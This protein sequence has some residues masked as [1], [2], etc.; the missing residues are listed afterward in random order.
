M[1]RYNSKRSFSKSGKAKASARWPSG[2]RVVSRNRRIRRNQTNN[3]AVATIRANPFPQKMRTTLAITHRT[4][5][6]SALT[7]SHAEVIAPSSYF[8]IV[9]TVGGPSFG[10]FGTY[11]AMY[12]RYRVLAF[13]YKIDFM[14]LEPDA[15]IVTAQSIASSTTPVTGTAVDWT[16][17]AMENVYGQYRVLGSVTGNGRATM[18]GF[19]NIAKLWG[20]P[21]V[22]TDNDWS[23]TSGTSPA[24]NSWL[25]VAAHKANNA[26]MT[27][28]VQV[29]IQLK[30]YGYWDVPSNPTS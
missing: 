23:G 14:N 18:K 20:T 1:P 15:V 22:Y 27:I 6:I 12:S 3:R 10:G 9:P 28:G 2:K 13:R 7:S 21:E 5:L 30:S 26:A 4:G 19:V 16:E 24:V 29:I 17:T 8:D 11:A 25:R